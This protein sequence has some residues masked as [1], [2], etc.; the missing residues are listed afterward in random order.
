[1]YKTLQ[2]CRAC[3][4]GKGTPSTLKVSTAAGGAYAEEQKLIPVFD[5]G[6]QPLANDFVKD[7]REHKGWAPLKVLYCPRC[8]LAQ[9]SVVVN[10]E[11]LY[12]NYPYVTS[13]SQT[14]REHFDRLWEIFRSQGQVNSILEIGSNDGRF[15]NYAQAKGVVSVC[16]IDPAD[17]LAVEARQH[18]VKTLTAIFNEASAKDAALW[19][20]PGYDLILARHVFCHVENWKEFIR[21]LEIPSNRHTMVC[22]E[23]PY[24]RDM[25][26]RGEF[27]TIYHE[28]TS[29]LTVKSI[30]ALLEDTHW[31]LHCVDHL[32]I[33]GGALL[34]TLRRKDYDHDPDPSVCETTLAETM[35]LETWREFARKSQAKIDQLGAY[36]RH[37]RS[38]GKKVVGYGASAK[39]SVW[40][41]ACGFTRKELSFICDSTPHK[42][43]ATSPGSD[44]PIVDEGAL[45]RELPD[46]AVC[47]CWNFATEVIA[48]EKFFKE[49]GGKWILPHPEIQTV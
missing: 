30:V 26:E 12:A 1:M 16:G 31:Q 40:V 29:Y 8:S 5:L 42:Q 39:S 7:G 47:F 2:A 22:I 18:G 13:T 11:V 35:T 37:L 38:S 15:L 34:L 6:V 49:K 17:N 9:L 46:Y 21:C 3:G 24:A 23:V 33:H 43:Y 27:D 44:I 41:S 32:E 10:P 14:M 25:L 19:M 28:H 48:K 36:V 20:P 45:T 4:L